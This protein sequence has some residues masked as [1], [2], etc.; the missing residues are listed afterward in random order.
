MSKSRLHAL[1]F[2]KRNLADLVTRKN[3]I[4]IS[5]PSSPTS[6]HHLT[7]SN[8]IQFTRYVSLKSLRT[9][10]PFP[11]PWSAIF[12]SYTFFRPGRQWWNKTSYPVD[13]KDFPFGCEVEYV[14]YPD[15][16][17]VVSTGAD[18]AVLSCIIDLEEGRE[19][20]LRTTCQILS[21]FLQSQ[22]RK[23]FLH[24]HRQH[25]TAPPARTCTPYPTLRRVFLCKACDL[26]T[27]ANQ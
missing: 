9:K 18:N 15:S 12:R 7:L 8:T 13:I 11:A 24:L 1:S 14:L 27:P 22:K 4:S 6:T 26:A 21:L 20:V 2:R 5:S 10:H 25:D 17:G 19:E 3:T 23:K 16:S